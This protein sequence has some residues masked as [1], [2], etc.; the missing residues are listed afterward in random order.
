MIRRAIGLVLILTGLAG[1]VMCYLG[2][3]A[4]RDLV[5]SVSLTAEGI[6][7]KASTSLTTVEDSLEQS[8]QT[9]GGITETITAVQTTT[10]NLASTV[11]DTQ[12]MLDELALLVG[13]DIPNTIKDVQDTIPNIA[14]TAKV[15]DDTLRLLS[16]LK[17]EQTIPLINYQI[18]FGLGVEYDPEIPFDQAVEEV[19][20]GLAPLAVTSGDLEGELK[21]TRTNMAQLSQD[22]EGLASGLER[23]NG[24]TSQFRPLLDEYS[25]LVNDM[26]DEIARASGQLD[27]QLSL[28]K[29]VI[30]LAAVWLSL[31]QLLPI[32][33]GIE[34]LMGNRMVRAVEI[35]TE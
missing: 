17:V 29:Q 32:Y 1:L 34:L 7:D 15:V 23:L 12:P 33:I 2:A 24:E 27:D 30:V 31:S 5:D 28:A 18:S 9:I 22:L 3:R 26:Q 14:Q 35:R 6:L 20:R 25:T 16:K 10:N 13:Q 4:G 21:T 19:G 11:D 8:R